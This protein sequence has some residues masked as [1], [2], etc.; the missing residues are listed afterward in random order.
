LQ[1]LSETLCVKLFLPGISVVIRRLHDTNKPHQVWGLLFVE[2]YC[3]NSGMKQFV[4]ILFV[5][6]LFA[7]NSF[8]YNIRRS[9][10]ESYIEKV[11]EGKQL[12]KNSTFYYPKLEFDDYTMWGGSS[13]HGENYGIGW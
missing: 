9:Q 13:N 11:I 12:T 10:I 4:N 1:S 8:H 5:L 2:Q 6:P 7:Q 3:V